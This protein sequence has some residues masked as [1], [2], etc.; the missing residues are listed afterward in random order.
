M[1]SSKE[2][3]PETIS[4]AEDILKMS[5]SVTTLGKA[6]FYA[7]LEQNTIN[8][9]KYFNKSKNFSVVFSRNWHFKFLFNMIRLKND[10]QVMSLLNNV[11]LKILLCTTKIINFSYFCKFFSKN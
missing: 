11:Y 8:A 4:I 9:Y 6:F 10:S 2:L 3:R 5:R 1:N 7:Q